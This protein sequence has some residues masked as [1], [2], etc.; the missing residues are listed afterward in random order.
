MRFISIVCSIGF[1]INVGNVVKCMI[2]ND[3]EIMGWAAA[4]C[5]SFVAL[6]LSFKIKD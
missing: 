2:F 1:I 4:L 6:G 3:A 5:W